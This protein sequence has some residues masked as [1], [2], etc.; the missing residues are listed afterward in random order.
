MN[1]FATAHRPETTMQS[2]DAA[3][4]A[5]AFPGESLEAAR[6]RLVTAIGLLPDQGELFLALGHLE[7][8]LENYKAALAAFTSAAALLPKAAAAHSGR[9]LACLKLGRSP[10]AAQ[11][12]IRA[13][14]LDPCDAA[15]LKVLARIHLDAGQ[16]EAAEQA[17]RRVLR[18]DAHDPEAG[19]MMEEAMA[20][21]AKLAENLF[22]R[23]PCLAAPPRRTAP[24]PA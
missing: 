15:G 19:R 6:E 2:D 13:V 8:K 4:A 11:A 24:R 16:H 20:Q 21:A 10:E 18:D 14:W 12:A 3:G 23:K 5:E 22:D 1:A 17:C 9:A 7:L